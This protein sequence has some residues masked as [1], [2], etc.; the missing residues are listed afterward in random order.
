MRES[1]PCL[2]CDSSG[3]AGARLGIPH[4]LPPPVLHLCR[5]RDDQTPW[6][7]LSAKICLTAY[8]WCIKTKTLRGNC[9]SNNSQVPHSI[10]VD[11]QANLFCVFECHPVCLPSVII[12]GSQPCSLQVLS[13]SL[14]SEANTLRMYMNTSM[15][16]MKWM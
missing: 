9:V 15:D 16:E 14:L 3:T 6:N 2:G 7:E 4:V 8:P 13:S 1:W 5:A 11:C 12:F 10:S